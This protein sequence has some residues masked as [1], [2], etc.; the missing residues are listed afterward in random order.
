MPTKTTTTKMKTH[1]VSIQK[2]HDYYSVDIRLLE[3][4]IAAPCGE[5]RRFRWL[6][7]ALIH[8]TE[9]T[10]KSIPVDW[11]SDFDALNETI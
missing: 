10:G 8:I 5:C 3:N 7:D 4:G 2:R 6:G 1:S 9:T 11:P